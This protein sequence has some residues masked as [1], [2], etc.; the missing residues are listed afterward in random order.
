MNKH[1][2]P[3]RIVGLRHP[4]P[5][6]TWMGT[7][8]L[9][10]VLALTPACS[11]L[12]NHGPTPVAQGKYFGSGN[13]EYDEFFLELYRTQVSMVAAPER[14]G[15]ARVDLAKGLGLSEDLPEQAVLEHVNARALELAGDGRRMQL[16][17]R[18]AEGEKAPTAVLLTRPANR[19]DTLRSLADPVE[20]ASNQLYAL[21]SELE[22]TSASIDQMQARLD[23][24]KDRTNATFVRDGIAKVSDVE[25][26]LEDAGKVLAYM[27]EQ[28]ATYLKETT[29][30]LD[31]LV[32]VT[33]T[34]EGAFDQPEPA[35][36]P[37]PVA[38][39]KPAKKA[40]PPPRKAPRASPPKRAPQPAPK[41]APAPKAPPS[42]PAGFEP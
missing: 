17:L 9:G 24:L 41:P 5:L 10:A 36:A 33:D 31:G 6:R 20:S 4:T 30:L 37:E 2:L 29:A 15:A 13:P 26:N 32:R 23:Q 21:Q 18:P 25:R 14:L 3:A 8:L 28:A 38:Q 35:P 42:E 27:R 7:G 1:R 12:M 16:K 34:S 22:Q 40:A 11:A 19:D 39:P